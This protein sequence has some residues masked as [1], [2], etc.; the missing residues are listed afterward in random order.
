MKI[1]QEWL[2][3]IQDSLISTPYICH[4]MTEKRLWWVLHSLCHWKLQALFVKF[5][6]LLDICVLLFQDVT[7]YMNPCPYVVF[8]WT[9]VPLVFNLFRTMGLRHLPVVNN[10]GQVI[11]YIVFGHPLN[12]ATRLLWTVC[13]RSN[14]RHCL[15]NLPTQYGHPA[16]YMATLACPFGSRINQT[17]L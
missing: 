17:L 16:N 7:P 9:P 8:P 11:K 13:C 12:M 4:E 10:K 6:R 3:I 1:L 15:L 2:R 14:E 5:R